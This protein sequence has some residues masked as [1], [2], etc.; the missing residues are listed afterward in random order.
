[1]SR[2]RSVIAFAFSYGVILGNAVGTI[3]GWAWALT[4]P[5]AVGL[6]AAERALN[7]RG[8]EGET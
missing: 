3:G 1:M 2:P 7:E 4:V 6:W 5:A 8:G